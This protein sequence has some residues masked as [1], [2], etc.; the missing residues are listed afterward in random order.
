MKW[1]SLRV[2]AAVLFVGGVLAG[3]LI[4][5]MRALLPQW[6]KLA[7]MPYSP[8]MLVLEA[9]VVIHVAFW[10]R[11]LTVGHWAL[12]GLF[13]GL[14][15]QIAFLFPYDIHTLLPYHWSALVT[16]LAA[17]IGMGLGVERT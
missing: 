2:N 5:A 4:A 11:P 16:I 12:N 13:L 7:L 15:A 17:P 6:T 9:L 1:K 3:V 10:L 8:P 14:M